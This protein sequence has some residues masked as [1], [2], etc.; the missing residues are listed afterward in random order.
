MAIGN[1]A[2]P[3]GCTVIKGA[4]GNTALT[5]SDINDFIE[6]GDKKM[7][8][9]DYINQVAHLPREEQAQALEAMFKNA[10]AANS[11]SVEAL[12][13]CEILAF[14]YEVFQ[15]KIGL[16]DLYFDTG[17]Y[18]RCAEYCQGLCN[19]MN[20]HGCSDFYFLMGLSYEELNRPLD[21][22]QSYNMAPRSLFSLLSLGGTKEIDF[23]SLPEKTLHQISSYYVRSGI[24]SFKLKQYSDAISAF[25]EGWKYYKTADAATYMGTI[26]YEGLDVT[27][28]VGKA[29]ELFLM[30]A[31]I[32]TPD[33][34][35]R[36]YVATANYKLGVIYAT[37]NGFV[38]RVKAE[39][40]L[41]KAKSLGYDVSDGE[42]AT[43]LNS[44]PVPKKKS[45]LGSL[46]G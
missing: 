18:E 19:E 40:H 33:P 4:V 13:L 29:E 16:P 41:Q 34:E 12:V 5:S 45:F 8:K 26:C 1:N 6:K 24:L 21:A 31:N 7:T 44:I 46:F 3:K 43:L 2:F 23:A 11:S 10:Y 22:I 30:V 37:E 27:K 42:I 32:D 20:G 9:Q 15:Y 36:S 35:V 17:N 28:N 39:A 38:N 14:D 25:S